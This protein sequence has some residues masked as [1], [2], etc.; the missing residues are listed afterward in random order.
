MALLDHSRVAVISWR[1]RNLWKDHT[2]LSCCSTRTWSRVTEPVVIQ[3]D[4]AEGKKFF[5]ADARRIFYFDDFLGQ[6]FLGDRGEYIGR[7]QD[8]A[9]VD[10]MEMVRGSAHSRFI[11]TTREHLLQSALLLSERL[12]KSRVLDSRCILELRDYTYAHKARILYNHLYFSGL[13]QAY[14]DAV[15]A[16]DFFLK[17]IG[18][19]HFNPRLIEWLSTSLRQRDVAAHQYRDYVSRLLESPHEIWMHAFRNQISGSGAPH[20]P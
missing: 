20:T 13:P 10:F 16:N 1:S 6:F 8:M 9:V 17:I 7:N 11:L 15:L 12:A 18:H 4:I 5:R 2:R 3:A 14:K 19:Q